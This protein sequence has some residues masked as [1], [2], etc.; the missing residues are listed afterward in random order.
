MPP[1]S[2]IGEFALFQIP[3]ITHTLYIYMASFL[4]RGGVFRSFWHYRF[5]F[6]RCQ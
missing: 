2:V 5:G 6:F 3:L 4:R 1:R